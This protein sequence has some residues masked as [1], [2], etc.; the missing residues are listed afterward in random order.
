MTLQQRSEQLAEEQR[1][2]LL[3]VVYDEAARLGR[4]I[5]DVLWVSRLDSGQVAFAI[6]EVDPRSIAESVVEAA[7][8]SLPPT[9][10]IELEA[11]PETPSIA[12]DPD[13]MRQVLSNLLDNAVKYSPDGGRIRVTIIPNGRY[14]RF[15]VEDEGLGIPAG[16]QQRIFEKFYRVDPNL[17]RGVGGT[18]LGLYVSSELVRRMDGRLWV[19]SRE[20]E[21]SRFYVDLPL[22]GNSEPD[23]VLAHLA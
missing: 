1:K 19:E 18:G 17:T 13:K 12:I 8:V 7:S 11:S 3:A 21:G 15:G 9:L 22:A 20:G 4:I 10:S 16:E 14:L 2:R 5:D 6:E 23:E